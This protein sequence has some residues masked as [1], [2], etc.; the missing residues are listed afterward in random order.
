LL[1]KRNSLLALL[2]SIL[3]T[4]RQPSRGGF[5][6]CAG[7]KPNPTRSVAAPTQSAIRS[8]NKRMTAFR[9]FKN[10]IAQARLVEPSDEPGSA[11]GAGFWRTRSLNEKDASRA[12]GTNRASL[13][14]GSGS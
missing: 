6:A 12:K 11:S 9:P 14:D 1:T 7:A 5:C 8:I 4:A 10:L 3:D 13:D 2:Y